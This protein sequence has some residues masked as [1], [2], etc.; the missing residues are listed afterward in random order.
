MAAAKYQMTLNLSVIDHLGFNLYSSTP[1]VLSEVV[2]NAW[3]ADAENVDVSYRQDKV[4]ITDDGH[5]MSYED[6]NERFLSVGYRRRDNQPVMTPKHNRHVMGRKGIG[7][8]SLF[9]IADTIRVESVDADGKKNGFVMRASRIREAAE[10]SGEYHPEPIPPRKITLEK[11]TRITI[12]DLNAQA[13]TLGERALRTRLARRFSIIGPEYKFTVSINGDPIGVEDRDYFRKIEFLWSIGDVGDRYEK[14]ATAAKQKQRIEG[15][16]GGAPN[17]KV[18]GWVGTVD[19]RKSIEEI[20]NTV[21]LL[22]WGKLIQEDVLGAVQAGGLYTK[23]LVGELRA[24][25]LDVDDRDDITTSDRQRLKEDDPRYQQILE[26]FKRDVLSVVEANWGDWR[27]DAALDT[28]L[29]IPEIKEWHDSLSK[30]S[31]RFAGQLFAK[32]G[33]FPKENDAEKRELYKY[34]ILAFEKLRLREALTAIDE[35]EDDADMSVFQA[36][37]SG[38]DELEAVG[39]Y[40]IVKGRLEVIEKFRDIVPS[41]REK[42]IQTYLWDHLWLLHPSWERSATN[43]QLEEAVDKEFAK[44][45]AKLTDEEKAGRVDMRY[46]TAAGKHIIIELKK[47]DATVTVAGLVDQLQKYRSALQKL[48]ET[49]FP[50]EPRAIEIIVLH[51]KPLTP[52]S[53]S[54]RQRTQIL[55][56]LDARAIPYDTL[57]QEAQDSYKDYL[58]INKRL[59]KLAETID[60]LS[61]EEP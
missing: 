43:A 53:M 54:E 23:Y 33:K 5:G 24:D 20:N 46:R 31:K 25:F 52:Q 50:K 37:F 13:T 38:V 3:D 30:D 26:W 16:V 35:I 47:Y 4:V 27:G 21:V 39:Y 61:P 44:I 49:K 41:Q 28:A 1:A 40:D 7:K 18:S 56:A 51:G 34:T 15:V 32:I 12:R 55:A 8:L 45:D 14:Q 17:F 60:R 57:I 42:V 59:A 11:G 36:V 2:A 29:E 22:A 6:L 9:A 10:T 48:L 58:E 19:E